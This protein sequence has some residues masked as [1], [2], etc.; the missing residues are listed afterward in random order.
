M[1]TIHGMKGLTKDLE[2]K[3]KAKALGD[4]D[5]YLAAAKTPAGRQ[6]LAK[7]VGVDA[8]AILELANRVDL[9]RV[10]GVGEV[11]S[12]LLE[13]AGVDTVK[14]LSK[15]VPDNLLAKITE[16][17]GKKKLAKRLPT[18]KEVADWVA[19]AKALPKT[20]EY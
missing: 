20:L 17:N 12:N 19:Q 6:E 8:S 2:G 7:G 4:G 5:K 15:R 16:V 18:A 14:E 10:K 3:L 11:F 1:A 13:E 9:A